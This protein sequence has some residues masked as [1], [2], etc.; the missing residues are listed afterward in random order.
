M[1]KR[2]RIGGVSRPKR[3]VAPIRVKRS[4]GIGIVCALGPSAIRTSTRK[5][6]I[7]G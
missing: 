5:S 2:A 3:V 7:A 6:S 4:S 1:P